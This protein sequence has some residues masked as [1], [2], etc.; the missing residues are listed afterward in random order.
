MTKKKEFNYAN[1]TYRFLAYVYDN[2]IFLVL[3]ALFFVIAFFINI[4]FF[5][6]IESTY[7]YIKKYY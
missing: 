6:N 4:E 5:F 1:I 3:A 7:I 2:L